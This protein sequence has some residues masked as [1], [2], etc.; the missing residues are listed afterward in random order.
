MQD[1]RL[2]TVGLIKYGKL[3]R[4]KFKV[5]GV[6][7]N[8]KGNIIVAKYG[9]IKGGWR[10]IYLSKGFAKDTISLRKKGIEP[11]MCCMADIIPGGYQ[12]IITLDEWYTMNGDNFNVTIYEVKTTD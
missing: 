7:L 2:E 10:K 11:V 8:N 6:S 12:E 1:K 3:L 4:E 5:G 9:D